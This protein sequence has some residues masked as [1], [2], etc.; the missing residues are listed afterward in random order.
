[1]EKEAIVIGIVLHLLCWGY[2]VVC[3]YTREKWPASKRYT[4]MWVVFG[5]MMTLIAASFTVGLI[6]ALIVAGYFVASGIPMAVGA[7]IKHTLKDSQ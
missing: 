1:M 3:E 4:F 7:M 5:V 2:A 6:N